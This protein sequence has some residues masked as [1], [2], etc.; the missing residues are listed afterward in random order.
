MNFVTLFIACFGNPLVFNNEL[1]K[2]ILLSPRNPQGCVD[3]HSSS[4]AQKKRKKKTGGSQ[5]RIER[6]TIKSESI[7]VSPYVFFPNYCLL[8]NLSSKTMNPSE[9]HTHALA[10]SLYPKHKK[11]K[12]MNRSCN[13]PRARVQLSFVSAKFKLGEIRDDCC[14]LGC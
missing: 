1:T 7:P 10:A 12:M 14:R 9:Y 6:I 2:R 13:Q 5:E 3:E 11:R 4:P 8:P